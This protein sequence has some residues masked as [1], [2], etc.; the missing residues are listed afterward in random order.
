VSTI[1]PSLSKKFPLLSLLGSPLTLISLPLTDTVPFPAVND[2][3]VFS[4]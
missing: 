4:A 2:F 3:K 1:L